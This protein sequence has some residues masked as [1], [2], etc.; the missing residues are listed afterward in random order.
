MLHRHLMIPP[1]PLRKDSPQLEAAFHRRKRP[2]WISWRMHGIYIKVKGHWK[3][4]HRAVDKSGQT[5]DFLLTGQRDEQEAMRFKA[6]HRHGVPETI[7]INGSEA[8]AAAISGL[9]LRGVVDAQAAGGRTRR[10]RPREC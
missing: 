3:Y 10:A 5:I 6:I 2:A 1:W 9:M 4:L 7:T 8:N